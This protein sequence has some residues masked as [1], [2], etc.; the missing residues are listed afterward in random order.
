M[1][2]T[3]AADLLA[4][5]DEERA[6]LSAMS[7]AQRIALVAG[8]T[9]RLGEA[10]LNEV[11]ARGEYA[12][13]LALAEAP[14]S[15]GVRRLE[16]ATLEAL[17][18]VDDVFIAP[19]DDHEPSARSYYGRD[20]PFTL[21]DDALS[22]RIARR[23]A[24]AGACR[25][26]LVSPTAA[27]QQISRLNH[28]LTSDAEREI[29]ALPIERIVVLRPT[30]NARSGGGTL[31]QRFVHAYLS[32]QLLMLPRSVPFVT[33]AHLSRV[34]VAAIDGAAPGIS[35]IGAERIAHWF[36]APAGR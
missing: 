8:A 26:L 16:L 28:G 36:D 9:G 7:G 27:W 31:V 29:A 6:D 22:V 19:G 5:R 3:D 4:G 21:V 33:S 1:R 17:D 24:Q 11:L 34:A 2:R 32:V 10:L 20:A 12:R 15:L 35:V 30:R 23:A 18:R 13:V 25:L 14:M